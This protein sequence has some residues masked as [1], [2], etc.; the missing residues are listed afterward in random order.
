MRPAQASS[1]LF[2]LAAALVPVLEPELG[3]TERLAAA[4]ALVAVLRDGRL[5]DVVD[6]VLARAQLDHL[7]LVVDQMEELFARQ[8]DEIDAFLSALL[9]ACQALRSA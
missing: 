6:R 7:L 2:A 5:A 3:E 4:N 1:P 9:S 8:Q